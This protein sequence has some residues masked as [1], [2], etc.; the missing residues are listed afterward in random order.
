MKVELFVTLLAVICSA[1]FQINLLQVVAVFDITY[2]LLCLVIVG[3][4]AMKKGKENAHPAP[5]SGMGGCVINAANKLISS[6][7]QPQSDLTRI[8]GAFLSLV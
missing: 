1:V 2:R 7:E 5:T 3:Y 4:K 8:F 6:E